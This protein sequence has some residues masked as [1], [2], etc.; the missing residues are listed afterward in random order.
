MRTAKADRLWN[1][2]W[3]MARRVEELQKVGDY[4]TYDIL[5]QSIIVVRSQQRG[6]ALTQEN[7]RLN[8][9]KVDTWGGYVFVNMDPDCE[10]L[11]D[12]LEPAATELDPFKIERMRYR[13][14]KWLVA[15]CNWKVALQDL[16]GLVMAARD[17]LSPPA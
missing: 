5:D 12:Y 9:V 4:V 3:Q 6:D 15:P 11:R 10:P 14:R 8:E 13:W 16:T 7:L 17:I 1:K 2:V